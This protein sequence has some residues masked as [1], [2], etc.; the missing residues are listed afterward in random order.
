[1]GEIVSY[2]GKDRYHSSNDKGWS[3]GIAGSFT[4]MTPNEI[5][6][7]FNIGKIT[8]TGVGFLTGGICGGVWDYCG[9]SENECSI[10]I[11]NCYNGGNI[12]VNGIEDDASWAMAGSICGSPTIGV[13]TNCFSIARGVEGNTTRSYV[14]RIVGYIAPRDEVRIEN[15]Y[16]YPSMTLNG[17][18]VSS[19][20]P[21][22]NNGQ[23]Q[24]LDAFTSKE[25]L[26]K[27]LKWD[28]EIWGFG[29]AFAKDL[30]YRYPIIK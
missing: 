27:N 11:S 13:I 29:G 3:G 17:E 23:D 28:F 25:W 26:E 21:T 8:A 30:E 6:N 9:V 4:R 16:A 20:D 1:M 15:C 19:S 24:T 14:G 22:S 10:N 2:R 18:T 12:V 5:S 7:C